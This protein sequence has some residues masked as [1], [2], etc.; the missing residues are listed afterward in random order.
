VRQFLYVTGILLIIA[1]VY[2]RY[3][4]VVDLV[5]GAAFALVCLTTAPSLYVFVKN[6]L[7]TMESRFPTA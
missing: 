6:N 1:T 2:Q 3:H 5:G 7:Q 4:Y